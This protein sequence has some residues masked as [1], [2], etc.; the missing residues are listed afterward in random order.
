MYS[1]NKKTNGIL[2]IPA[3]GSLENKYCKNNIDITFF[4]PYLYNYSKTYFI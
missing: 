3:L 4:N 1:V 2:S